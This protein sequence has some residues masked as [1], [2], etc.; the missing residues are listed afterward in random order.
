MLR[1]IPVFRNSFLTAATMP[2]TYAGGQMRYRFGKRRRAA[3]DSRRAR[4]S[5][6]KKRYNRGVMRYAN[7]RSSA[8]AVRGWMAGSVLEKKVADTTFTATNV[9]STAV[10]AN[11]LAVAQGVA[12]TERVGNKII[13]TSIQCLGQFLGEQARDQAVS[14]LSPPQCVRMIVYIDKQPNGADPAAGDLL[15]D[16]ANVF[17][18]MNLANRDRFVI[19]KDIIKTIGPVASTATAG[20]VGFGGE[21][22]KLVKFYK[23]CRIPVTYG[24]TTSGI[25]SIKTN[26]I[27]VL[28]IG[29]NAT[30]ELDSNFN[31][32]LRFR[33]T[34]A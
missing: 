4:Y 20:Q 30:G 13:V 6:I 34:D 18:P 12:V 23:K 7:R 1:E 16:G 11:A 5:A 27:G 26:A 3:F 33:Y 29:G 24:G 25:A 15:N 10:I 2:F 17:S 21:G 8:L 31:G 9:S 28:F 14:L 32:Y 22:V 19:V